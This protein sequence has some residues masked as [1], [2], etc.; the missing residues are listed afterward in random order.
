MD[1]AAYAVEAEVERT[2]W[3]FVGR[4]RL[5]ARELQAAGARHGDRLLDIG[6][7]TGSNLRM[8]QELGFQNFAGLDASDEAIRFC[9]EKGFG[10]VRKGDICAMPFADDSFDFVMATD[11]I[12]HVDD[13]RQAAREIARILKPGGKALITVP[14]FQA[15]W[16]PQD[17]QAFH[18]RRYRMASLSRV[19]ESAGFRIERRYYF[20]YLLFVP[21]WLARKTIDAFGLA[22]RSEGEVNTPWL[23][24]L[25][26][27]VFAFDVVT[28]PLLRPPFGVSIFALV[29]KPGRA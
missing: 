10:Q 4:R 12:E 15:L 18:K 19:L 14:A 27:K 23:N 2:H 22:L 17:R 1:L 28:A 8:L 11:V 25:L 21:I 29:S 6:T 5:F 26:S 16:G 3:W 24:I 9:A 7:S 20:N 13:D